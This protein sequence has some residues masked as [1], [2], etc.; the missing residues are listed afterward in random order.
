MAAARCDFVRQQSSIRLV[1]C[2]T[3]IQVHFALNAMVADVV[4]NARVMFC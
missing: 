1:E 2:A 4:R 3:S